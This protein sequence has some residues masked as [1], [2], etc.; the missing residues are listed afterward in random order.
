MRFFTYLN[1][2][3]KCFF[4][5]FKSQISKCPDLSEIL[6]Y[7]LVPTLPCSPSSKVILYSSSTWSPCILGS[8]PKQWFVHIHQKKKNLHIKV[9]SD[10]FYCHSRVTFKLTFSI[11]ILWE[12]ED[13]CRTPHHPMIIDRTSP[14]GNHTVLSSCIHWSFNMSARPGWELRASDN[15]NWY[16]PYK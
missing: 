5:Y 12:S 4:G 11:L 14:T 15:L 9:R 6:P 2:D 13:S 7:F 16:L 1:F 8:S 10:E 3:E